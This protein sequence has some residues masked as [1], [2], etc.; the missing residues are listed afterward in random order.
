MSK[1]R[2]G[3]GGD[4]EVGYGKPP[5]ETQFQKG[6]C[7]N[8]NGRPKGTKNMSTI[9]HE[10]LFEPIQVQ[11]NGKTKSIP[12]IQAILLKVRNSALNGDY[13]AA[14]TAIQL[15]GRVPGEDQTDN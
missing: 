11:Q 9:V 14:M 8:P 2:K 1:G 7:G 6:Q 12:A 13:K 4:Y 10:I 3:R 15:A 5:K